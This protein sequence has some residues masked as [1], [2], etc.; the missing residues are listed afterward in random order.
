M[1][2]PIKRE[3][4]LIIP[5]TSNMEL[6]AAQTTT[7]LAELMGFEA[8]DIDALQLALIEICINAFEHSKSED[9]RVFITFMMRDDALE[10]KITDRGVGFRPEKVATSKAR[11]DRSGRKR[12]WGIEIVRNMVDT[13]NVQSSEKG[14]TVTIIKERKR[15][16][17]RACSSSSRNGGE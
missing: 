10:L 16:G 13:V 14:T 4:N 11:I 9:K 2:N 15:A 5:M 6:A 8:N 3:V 17:T 1:P 7:S 12:G